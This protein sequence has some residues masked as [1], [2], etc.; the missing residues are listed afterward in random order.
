MTIPDN[1]AILRIELEDIDPLIWRRVG[2]T[3]V[4]EPEGRAPRNSSGDGL[5]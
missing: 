4:D 2:G 3:Y 1:I 5:A